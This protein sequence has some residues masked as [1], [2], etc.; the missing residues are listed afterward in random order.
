MGR[1]GE[2]NAGSVV[3]NKRRQVLGL[4]G[5]PLF[6]IAAGIGLYVMYSRSVTRQESF[7]D[8]M[9]SAWVSYEAYASSDG[10]T[11]LGRDI[12][13]DAFAD[14]VSDCLDR[15][16]YVPPTTNFDAGNVPDLC[17]QAWSDLPHTNND[18]PGQSPVSRDARSGVE[19]A[20]RE[21]TTE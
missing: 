18:K 3:M 5:W 19:A 11:R 2:H 8:C 12:A 7:C 21:R 17:A 20:E 10:M 13:Q 9:R 14:A 15:T 1:R 16:G 6:L 4:A